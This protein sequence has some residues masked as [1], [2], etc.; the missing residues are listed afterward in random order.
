MPWR[1]ISMFE[2]RKN[3]ILAIQNPRRT[4]TFCQLCQEYNISTK[5]GYKWLHRYQKNGER[6]LEDL[7]RI[8]IHQPN[9]IS[10]D[11]ENCV[12]WIRQQY[13]TW[14]PKKIRAEIINTF[15][16]LQPPSEASIGNILIKHALSKP[17][18]LR[19][20]VARTAPL[21]ECNAPNHTWMYDFKGWFITKDGSKCE[22]LTITDGYSRYLIACTHMNRKR[23]QDVWSILEQA[24]HEYG[25]PDY[26]RSDN[27]P[28][29]AS[30]S[31]GRLSNLAIKLI[32]VG[33]TPEWIEPGCPQQNGRH[34]RFHLTLKKETAMPAALNL[35]LQQEKFNQFKTYFN[36]KRPHEALQQATPSSIYVPSQ[37][38][39]DGKFRSPEYTEEY[40]PRKVGRSGSITWKGTDFFLSEM[41]EGEYVGI[42]E[43]DV[44][45][46]GIYYGPI[47]LGKIDLNKGFRRV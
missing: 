27:G 25:L 31:L 33:I 41:L 1:N 14:G 16:Q 22:P 37:R 47:L 44:G 35:N 28:P 36:D 15:S 11:V 13:S 42:I 43:L 24:F 34:E 19:R 7:P 8:P 21:A 38:I 39:W 26:I 40:E 46:M 18:V 5:T 9:K 23:A 3:F 29:F 4:V 2:Q 10:L 12:I 17:R 32:K 6:G 20:H 30:L 45:L